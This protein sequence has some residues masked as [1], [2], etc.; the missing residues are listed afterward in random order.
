MGPRSPLEV[1]TSSV[2]RLVKEEAS[3]HREEQ[4]QKQR[5]QRMEGEEGDENKEF[6]L[7][8]ERL[9]LEETR[10]VFPSLKLKIEDNVKT[11]EHL[12]TEEGKK[13][14][15]SNVEH[16]T[17]AKEAIAKAKSAEREIS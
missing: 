17:A 2:L 10:K 1:Y 14:P 13:G 11:L 7:N 3:Y 6:L 5:I 9:A 15:E 12:L 16:I 4:D 8:Q